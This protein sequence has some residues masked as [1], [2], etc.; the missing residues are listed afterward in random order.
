MLKMGKKTQR[1]SVINMSYKA[2]LVMSHEYTESDEQYLRSIIRNHIPDAEI[3]LSCSDREN[4]LYHARTIK[5]V[6]DKLLRNLKKKNQRIEQALQPNID[7]L[8][9]TQDPNQ[10]ELLEERVCIQLEGCKVPNNSTLVKT[11]ENARDKYP[12][13]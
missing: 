4:I 3:V 13:K 8:A 12:N 9:Q 6:A 2:A 1:P 5:G 11:Y 10:R 7:L